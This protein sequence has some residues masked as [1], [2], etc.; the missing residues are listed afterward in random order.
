[1]T[2]LRIVGTFVSGFLAGVGAGTVAMVNVHASMPLT[3]AYAVV[4]GVL[5]GHL[6]WRD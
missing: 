5:V 1:M 4:A 3:V 6:T 2:A